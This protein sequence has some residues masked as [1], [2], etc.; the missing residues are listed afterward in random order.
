[1]KKIIW[2]VGVLAVMLGAYAIAASEPLALRPAIPLRLAHA[3]RAP[4][5]YQLFLP[6]VT[7]GEMWREDGEKAI[8]ISALGTLAVAKI[9]GRINGQWNNMAGGWVSYSAYALREG[10]D[11]FIYAGG[12]SSNYPYNPL[13][14]WNGVSWTLN[15]DI[16]SGTIFDLIFLANG[17]LIVAGNLVGVGG[18]GDAKKIARYDGAAWNMLGS[19]VTGGSSVSTLAL[20]QDGTVYAG[21]AF[22]QMGGVANTAYIAKWNGTSWSALSTGMNGWVKKIVV[23]SDG[24]VYAGGDFT[25]AGGVS[26]NR[27]AKWNGTSWSALGTGCND[28]VNA[29]V[30]SPVGMLY[31]GGIFTSA[32]GVA[33]TAG[34]AQWNGQTWSSVG[35]WTSGQANY[36]S[37]TP[38]GLVYISGTKVWDGSAWRTMDIALPGG[39]SVMAT[40]NA[41]GNFYVAFNNGATVTVS[42]VGTTT[43]TNPSSALAY[44]VITL[45][46]TGGTSATIQMIRNETTGKQLNFNYALADGETLTID[47]RPGRRAI[48]SSA[49]GAA[50]SAILPNSHFSSF[51]L[52]PGSNTISI[53]VVPAGSPTVTCGMRW[54]LAYAS[55]R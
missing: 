9:A 18:L 46:R 21:G 19:G 30:L 45:K 54:T 53:Y 42:G 5:I 25:T 44:P 17:N 49:F 38:D 14:Y 40:L 41:S 13:Q 12:V 34:L 33:L 8:S 11:K 37:V 55:E 39:W 32:G 50:L 16:T 23:A 27:V 7:G 10:P 52:A 31:A 36:L 15:P 22:T 51:A 48:T 29:L 47:L 2:G 35:G 20:A 26:A 24:T 28:T 3:E 6:V 43:I 1:M 4:S